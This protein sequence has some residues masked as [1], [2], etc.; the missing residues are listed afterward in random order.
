M[1]FASAISRSFAVGAAALIVITSA[2]AAAACLLHASSVEPYI[3]IENPLG[4]GSLAS[5]IWHLLLALLFM[6]AVCLYY[7]RPK[8]RSLRL[9]VAASAGLL[10]I[11][12]L[13]DAA[14]F[15]W[16]LAT[17]RIASSFPV[18][19]S[20][21]VAL[22]AGTFVV[23]VGRTGST[24]ELSRRRI[25][26]DFIGGP[27]GMTLLVLLHLV[28]FGSTDYVRNADAAVVLGAKVY[29]D[30]TPST[31]LADRLSTGIELY[32]SGRVHYLLMTGGTGAEG[33]NEAIAMRDYALSAGVPE[34]SIL[35]DTLGVNTLAS[36]RNCRSILSD[37]GI[38]S[39]LLVS[40]Y[41]HLARCKMLFA[42]Q[43]IPCATVPARMSQR[44]RSEPFFVLRECMAY[45]AYSVERPWRNDTD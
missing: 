5:L 39:V 26:F 33:Y 42:E 44:L 45:L 2:A 25:A 38:G 16:L 37:Q 12:A 30:G 6:F 29:S 22:V 43:G 18:P 3:W 9:V 27:V 35:V 41:F 34:Q 4:N 40:H 8:F 23:L 21:Y 7:L 14:I 10:A 20:L 28:T 1:D 15:Y 24:S 31:S 19:L 17:G 36:A 11:L 32:K 13:K